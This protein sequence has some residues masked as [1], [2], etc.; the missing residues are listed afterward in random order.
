MWR[1]IERDVRDRDGD[2]LAD[3]DSCGEISKEMEIVGYCWT[4]IPCQTRI[5]IASVEN[6]YSYVVFF[7]FYTLT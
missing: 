1:N 5:F 4:N 6:L 2:R 7:R 3:G